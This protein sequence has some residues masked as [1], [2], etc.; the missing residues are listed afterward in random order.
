MTVARADARLLHVTARLQ[1]GVVLDGTPWPMPLD[2]IMA[3]AERRSIL[4]GSYGIV[5]DHHCVNLPLVRVRDGCGAQWVWAA[6]AAATDPDPAVDVRFFHKRF[7]TQAAETVVDRLPAN[8]DTGLTKGWRIPLPVTVTA[9]LHWTAAGDPAAVA[10]ILDRVAQLGK[11]RA[12]GEGVVIGW[13]VTDAGPADLD[14]VLCRDGHPSRPIPARAAQA[15]GWTHD[16]ST[17]DAIR[18]P[19]WRRPLN[20]DTGH[21]EARHV[22][23]PWAVRSPT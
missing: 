20:P 9:S 13:D 19:Y 6:S 16:T 7:D 1:S 21:R 3:A 22:I 8:T 4:A 23:A 5:V 17:H 12:H 14:A 15:L 11:K 10:A 18:P 2:G